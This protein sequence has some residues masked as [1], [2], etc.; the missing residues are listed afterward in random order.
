M[1]MQAWKNLASKA[2]ALLVKFLDLVG[3]QWLTNVL[4]VM[5]NKN[6]VVEGSLM[7]PTA[8]TRTVV[9]RL[10][11]KWR[12]MGFDENPA[13]TSCLWLVNLRSFLTRIIRK[14]W[15]Y[16]SHKLGF[17][18]LPYV[19]RM[20][21][22][23]NDSPLGALLANHV[24]DAFSTD[25][26]VAVITYKWDMYA[27]RVW[28][29]CG[30]SRDGECPWKN[31]CTH[32]QSKCSA[33][34][35]SFKITRLIAGFVNTIS[36][37]KD[38]YSDSTQASEDGAD[39]QPGME[40]ASEDGANVQPGMEQAS[41]DGADVQPGM[42][43]ASEDGA[44]IQPGMEQASEDGADVQPGMEQASED[45]AN[46]QPGMEKSI[47]ASGQGLYLSKAGTCLPGCLLHEARVVPAN[48]GQ[49]HTTQPYWNLLA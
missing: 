2:P 34:L 48:Y 41:E 14:P 23:V 35:L 44:N 4:E 28:H 47:L 11:R 1:H 29:H 38:W 32:L 3:I 7:D 31:P 6:L 37:I 43:Q 19:A 49:H 42:E 36:Q 40:Q 25:A 30:R 13:S 27:A 18:A 21:R 20:T 24:Y 26:I 39:V 15:E 8:E 33:K 5:P 10:T 9:N 46:I 22:S 16:C 45:G 12:R 17:C